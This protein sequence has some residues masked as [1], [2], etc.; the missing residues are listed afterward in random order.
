MQDS[1]IGLHRAPGVARSMWTAGDDLSLTIQIGALQEKVSNL[2]VELCNTL[3]CGLRIIMTDVPTFVAFADKG[4]YIDNPPFD[5]KELK[6]DLA[7][8]IQTY[9]VTQALAQ[10]SWKALRMSEIS[11]EDFGNL[12]G[13]QS[14]CTVHG[15]STP[16]SNIKQLYWSPLSRRH[17]R[18]QHGG[19]ADG[20][21]G[22]SLEKIREANWADLPLLFDSAFNCAWLD[23]RE[24]TQT[25]QVIF[26][27]TLDI[28]CVSKIPMKR[29]CGS[30]CSHTAGD[31]SCLFE[32]AAD[33]SSPQGASSVHAGMGWY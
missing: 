27:G 13:P 33:C 28:G 29:L 21:T 30:K 12:H 17:Y 24:D 8:I 1:A 16:N 20:S 23:E 9:V 7:V 22:I 10:N 3:S 19:S 15:C 4:Q 5:P 25:V 2:T 14:L 26:D 11:K 6:N 31:G 18:A 32:H